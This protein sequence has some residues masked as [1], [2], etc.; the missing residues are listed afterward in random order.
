MH[1]RAA[2]LGEQ[3]D[4]IELQWL[5]LHEALDALPQPD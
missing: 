4:A 1:K 5:E 2:D 3:I